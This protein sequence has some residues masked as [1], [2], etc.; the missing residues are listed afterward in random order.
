AMGV[1]V[2]EWKGAWWRQINN[3]GQ[4]K[5]KRAG[6][7]KAGKK[8]AEAAAGQLQAKLASGDVRL[9][10]EE[11]E[12][13]QPFRQAACRWLD[14]YS[15]LGQLRTS[16]VELYKRN[17]RT[18]V[19]PRFGDRPVTA[20]TREDVRTL[21]ADLLGQGKS[22]SLVRNVVAPIRQTFNQLAEDGVV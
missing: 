15:K 19:Y 14:A 10:A 4:R 7:G 2:K 16:T 18:Y 1:K 8:A 3:K 5:S 11:H 20:I 17:L 12:H 13:S 9:F 22:R 6:V 21:V